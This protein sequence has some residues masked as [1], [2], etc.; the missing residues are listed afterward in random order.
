MRIHIASLLGNLS[1]PALS[2]IMMKMTGPWP[3]LWV[4]I[5][6]L[7]VSAVAFSFVPETLQH[8]T[9]SDVPGQPT[10]MKKHLS[11]F[12]GS[13]MESVNMLKS[14]SLIIMLTTSLLVQ[15]IY[16]ATVQLL[17][18]YVSKRY[19][20]RIEDTGYIQTIYGAAQV[21]QA[22]VGLPTISRLMTSHLERSTTMKVLRIRNEQQRDLLLARSSLFIL[23]PGLFILGVASSLGLFIFGLLV[24][25]IGA[26]YSSYTRSLMS[27]FVESGRHSRLFSL[28]AMVDVAGSVYSGPMLAGLFSA[29]MDLGD[30]WVGLPYFVL[31]AIVSGAFIL[32]L[33]VRLPK[34]D[35]QASSNGS[36]ETE[37]QDL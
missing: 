35:A 33:F 31:A 37:S 22:L 20:L 3:V 5:T 26:G 23:V 7:L 32:L 18:Q 27:L 16:F 12:A 6:C 13:I 30:A 24:L 2:S 25:A 9:S 8:K 34:T 36:S 14:R 19:G 1:S 28:V 11:D 17:I 21:F 10:S 4:G 15:P 29:G